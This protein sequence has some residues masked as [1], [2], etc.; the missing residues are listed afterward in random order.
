[1]LFRFSLAILKLNEATLLQKTDTIGVMR[2]LKASAGLL[3]DVDGLIKVRTIII[4]ITFIDC[5]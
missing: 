3:F 4:I 5:K 2:H 1:M